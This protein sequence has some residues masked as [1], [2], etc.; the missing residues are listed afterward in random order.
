[1]GVSIVDI[2]G[3][4]NTFQVIW[5]NKK[6]YEWCRNTKNKGMN[7]SSYLACKEVFQTTGLKFKP[8]EAREL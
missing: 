3:V 2:T 6:M 8:P 5:M 1:M 7:T 4:G